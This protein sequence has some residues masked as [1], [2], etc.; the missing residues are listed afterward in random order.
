MNV[1]DVGS[2]QVSSSYYGQ[3][4]KQFTPEERGEHKPKA[5]VDRPVGG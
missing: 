4:G 5:N 2:G 3:H 1:H